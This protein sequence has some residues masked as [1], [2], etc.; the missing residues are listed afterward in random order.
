MMYRY[1]AIALLSISAAF[2][3]PVPTTQ[4]PLRPA[5][6]SEPPKAAA[7]KPDAGQADAAETPEGTSAPAAR[8]GRGAGP[9]PILPKDLKYPPLRPIQVPNITS[10][11]LPNGMKLLLLEDHELPI[12]NGLAMVHAGSLLDPP[13]RVGMAVAAGALL[14]SG[15]TSVKTPDQMDN[16][17]E[18]MAATIDSSAD[19][20]STRVSFATVKENLDTVLGVFKEV[21]TAP[22][23][24][25]D[26]IEAIRAQMRTAISSRND[27]SALLAQRELTGVVYG[28][29]NPFGWL[30]QYGTIDR[31]TRKDLQAYYQR[32]FVPSNTSLA[33]WGDFD[34][35]QMKETIEKRFADWTPAAQAAPQFPK[36]KDATAGGVYLAE[37]KEGNQTSFAVGEMGIRADDKDMAAL[38][39][40][41]GI[42][43]S[44]ANGRIPEK[45]KSRTGATH[46]IRAFWSPSYD[47]PG[48]FSIT[49]TTGSI[50]TVD[51]L[52]V[53]KE[54]VQRIT[55]AEVTDQELTT[56][57][58]SML[59][60]LVFTYDTRAK[61]LSR[62]LLLDFYGYPKDYLP[63]FQK[64]LQALT[65]ADILRA[66]KQYLSPDKLAIVVVANLSSFSDPLEKLGGEVTHLDITI[67]ESKVEPVETTD[68]SLA[69]GKALLQKAQAAMGG[70]Q[71]LLAIKDYT[72][73]ASYQIDGS[74]PNVGGMKV[75]ETDKWMAPTT[76]RQDSVLPAGRVAAFT[77]G[78][79]GW[80]ATP[81]GWG[82]L[83]GTQLKQVQSDLFRTWFRL[84]LSDLV[85]GRIVNAVDG[86]SVQISDPVG[87][88]SKVEFD[89][90]TGLPKRITYDTPQAIG[91]PLY[92]EDL[93]S[94]F[95]EVDGVKL[96]FQITINQSG[97]KFADVTVTEYKLNS[98]LK[99]AELSKRPM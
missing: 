63:R 98:G 68:A 94:D 40:I 3:Q 34:A 66:A 72:E 37:K 9:S 90:E 85:E 19:E 75:T 30:P 38:Q 95:R 50:G 48:M 14:R 86:S 28:R 61:L 33:L 93:L 5:P 81:Q 65:K 39:V 88:G 49:G 71:K 44:G 21:L 64:S 27:D 80:I 10:F 74:V 20:S 55:T 13:E 42:L 56:T 35:A 99:L 16:I 36:W 12:V 26:K 89:S 69:E 58:D 17:L 54:E 82:G 70:V 29:D 2:A 43:A 97:K 78:R 4:P 77:D 67:P 47:H 18:T 96:P 15:G 11:T 45:A 92:T 87:Q 59:N 91:P 73:V 60:A 7:P 83:T 62:L 84:L 51:V 76:F 31:I 46:E 8:G 23:F 25:Q 1:L 24:R 79:L 32:Y 22:E 41:A 57:R 52:R 53:V 6:K